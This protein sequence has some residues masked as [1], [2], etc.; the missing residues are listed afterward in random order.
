MPRLNPVNP[1]EATGAVK[2]IFDG[3]L[4]GK[5]LNIFTSM[6]HS[7]A[8]LGVYLGM[9]G[10]LAKS[11]LN[12]REREV[13]QLA[14]AQD[15]QCDYCLAAHTAIGVQSGLSADETR[16]A[17]K[18]TLH[19]AKLAAL[20]RF[21]RAINHGKGAVSDADVRAVRDAGYTDAQIVDTIACVA[22]AFYTNAFNRFNATAV[23]FPTPP[24]L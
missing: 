23:D 20:A 5:T 12:P 7:P 17:R 21:A 18:G 16:D 1:R 24:A 8:A 6:A 2:D 4:S 11:S 19:D 9:A 22:L 3:P 13:I 14:I 15:N 10:P